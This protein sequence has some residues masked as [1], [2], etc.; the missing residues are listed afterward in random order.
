MVVKCIPKLGDSL[1]EG[2]ICY[3]LKISHGVQRL[4]RSSELGFGRFGV[5]QFFQV[6]SRIFINNVHC[7]L[8]RRL[9]NSVLK[10][11]TIYDEEQKASFLL[12]CALRVGTVTF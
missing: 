9:I 3:S 8:R 6:G 1:A 4:S 5:E 10:V 7:Q 2:P 12:V 11:D